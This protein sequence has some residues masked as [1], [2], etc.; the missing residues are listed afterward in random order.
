[1]RDWFV[2]VIKRFYEPIADEAESLVETKE[3]SS[4]ARSSVQGHRSHDLGWS[5]K[6]KELFTLLNYLEP[7]NFNSF[8][9]FMDQFGELKSKA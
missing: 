2:K 7:D 6:T 1:M 8:D 9:R 3:P 5:P 4:Q